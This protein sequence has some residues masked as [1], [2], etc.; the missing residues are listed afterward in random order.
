[1]YDNDADET[2]LHLKSLLSL[3][4]SKMYIIILLAVLGAACMFFK[5]K[6]FTTDCYVSEGA[7]VVSNITE[8]VLSQKAY[9]TSSDMESSKS[10][11]KSC[12]ELLQRRGFFDMVSKDT[13]GKYSYSQIAKMVTIVNVNETEVLSVTVKANDKEDAYA[14]CNSIIKNA[15]SWI[16]SIYE[17]GVVK[18][19]DEAS[20]PQK[21]V[22]KNVA[23]NIFVGFM[24][25]AIAGAAIIFVI[26]FFDDKVKCGEEISRKYGFPLL[27]ELDP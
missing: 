4:I 17:L 6:Y 26:D 8:E 12:M 18:K 1:M 21:P 22:S 10:L 20:M 24:L 9:L 11:S 15:P 2:L 5:V 14:V 16:E 23:R 13:G 7:L 19:A 25:G 27:G 3:M